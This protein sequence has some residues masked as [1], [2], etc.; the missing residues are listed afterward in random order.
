MK[1]LRREKAVPQLLIAPLIDIVFLLLIFFMLVTNF[2]PP[3]IAIALPESESADI[4][5][6]LSVTVSVDDRGI[7]YLNETSVN[8]TELTGLLEDARVN[9]EIEIVRLRADEST[10]WQRV[11]EI[12]DAIRSA[13]ILDIAIET[14]RAGD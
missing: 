14:Q 9:G 13:G 8:L 4:N 6:S 7:I 12:F 10:E 3:S 2:L 5:E 11:I 1:R